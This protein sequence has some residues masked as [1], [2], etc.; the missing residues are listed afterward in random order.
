M[1]VNKEQIGSFIPQ[2]APFI[3]IDNLIEAAP[4][5]FETDFLILPNNI[6]LDGA[7]LRE[8]ALIE[9]I[10]QSSAAGICFLNRSSATPLTDGLMG[11][12]SRLQLYDLPNIYDRIYT[13]VNLLQQ[14]GN[15]YLL[16]G[17]TYVNGRKL[18]ECEV[19]LV[20]FTPDRLDA[21][22]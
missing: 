1:K 8:F 19:K 2:R 3:M 6:F 13:I 16:R 4:N 5:R 18:M 17:E 22:S 21:A 12:I 7:V 20:G 9:N 11:G 10:A 14:L 15:M